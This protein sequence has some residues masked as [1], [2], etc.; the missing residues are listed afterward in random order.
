MNTRAI[1]DR[2]A[3]VRASPDTPGETPVNG[4][5][6]IEVDPADETRLVVQFIFDV[7]TDVDPPLA[8]AVGAPLSKALFRLSGGERIPGVQVVSIAREDARRVRVQADRVGDFSVYELSI[9]TAAPAPPAGEPPGPPQV[10]AGFDPVLCAVPFVFHVECAKRFDCKDARRCPAPAVAAPNIDY[11][12]RDYPAFVQLMLDR[13]ALLAPRWR[14]RSAAD[15]G[16]TLV[17]VLAYAADQLGYRHDVIETEAYLGTARLRTSVRRHARLVDYRI[18][19]GSNARVWLVL[20]LN[21]DLPGGVPAGT[22]CCTRFDGAPP[23][24]LTRDLATYEAA[25]SAGAEFFEVM[26]DRFLPG[27]D[28]PLPQPRPLRAANNTM[29]FYA[30]SAREDCLP[31]GATRATLAGAHD[32]RRGDFLMFAEA[33]GPRSGSP[34]DADPTRRCVVRLVRDGEVSTDPLNGAAITRI[35]WHADDALPFPL[36]IASLADA[37]G[38][39]SLT[40]VSMAYGNVILADHGRTL[41][42]PVESDRE[43]LPPEAGVPADR[44]YRPALA[45]FPVTMA[46]AN[47]YLG[48]RPADPTQLLQSAARAASWTAAD[49]S[50]TV[51]LR[52]VDGGGNVLGWNAVSD[53]LDA[54]VGPQSPVIELEV[55]NDGRAYARFGDGTTGMAV[56][57]GMRFDASYRVGSGRAGM[58]A[59]DTVV[60]IDPAFPGAGFI[61]AVSNSMPAFGG[62]DAESI[63]HVR[64]NA[65]VAFRTQL[66]AVTPADYVARARQFPGVQRAAATFRW[67]GSWTTVFLTVERTDDAR[68]DAT[69]RAALSDYL[70]HYRLAGCDIEVEDAVRVPL[71]V[72]M[73]V[74]VSA[75]HVAAD[76]ERLLQGLFT[77]G[78]TADGTPGVFHPQRFLMG[79]PFYLSPL[80]AAAQAVDGVASV[81]ITRFEREQSPDGSGLASGVLV[82]GPIELF[83]LAND[84]DFPERGVFELDVEGR[85]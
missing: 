56:E 44:R 85:L 29:A 21:G 43:S 39:P 67:T 68:V 73:H 9:G 53:M 72:A 12:A 18:D 22:R 2:R 26:A 19:D 35:A 83:E 16:V 62:R 55:E 36:C 15:L 64:Q 45:R 10:P 28:P 42:A 25:I 37:S 65:P 27:S 34:A 32:L 7:D 78:L 13:M 71:R 33:K 4:I 51:T 8:G 46:A 76:V 79:E 3:I 48:D 74:C 6:F 49:V 20:Q 24:A 84:P 47:P 5:D 77:S 57:P 23:L 41:G 30:W 80:V 69:F 61:D 66:R 14:E 82:P 50:P 40:D 1:D 58:V 63:E 52:S 17:E 31:V 81:S 59:A 54:G 75:G 11:L 60:L 38:Q 70:E